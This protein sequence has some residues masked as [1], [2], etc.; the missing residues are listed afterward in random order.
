MATLGRLLVQ[1]PDEQAAM[2]LVFALLIA[3]D[4]KVPL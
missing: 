3:S 2:L 1:V 4:D